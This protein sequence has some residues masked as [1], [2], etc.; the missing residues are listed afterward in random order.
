MTTEKKTHRWARAITIGMGVVLVTAGAVTVAF[1]QYDPPQRLQETTFG[2]DDGLLVER[3]R[4]AARRKT[5]PEDIEDFVG[6][7]ATI[8]TIRQ[9]DKDSFEHADIVVDGE[10]VDSASLREAKDVVYWILSVESKNPRLVGVAWTA[11]NERKVFFGVVL[12]PG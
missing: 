5:P 12:P 2:K 4:E 7:K 1:W 11:A 8:N 10:E 3:I 9:P 6:E